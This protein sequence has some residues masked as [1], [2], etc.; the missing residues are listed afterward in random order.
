MDEKVLKAVTVLTGVLTLVVCISL[1]FLPK[2]HEK[3]ALAAEKE[4][5]IGRADL[6]ASAD[7][8]DVVKKADD[9]SAQIK[10]GLPQQLT[11]EQLTIK[12]DY[13][14]QTVY[15]RFSGGVDDY[16]DQYGIQGNCDHIASLFYYRDGDEGVIAFGL[17]RVYEVEQ[18]FELG[19]LYLDFV[20]PHTIYDKVIVIDAGHGDRAPGVVKLGIAEKDIDL[21]ILLE[22][23][24][25]LE[26]CP[27]N[28]GVYYTRTSD[29]NPTFEQRVQLANKA[30]ADLFISI[31]NNSDV[32]GNFTEANGTHVM[33]SESNDK[34]LSGQKLAQICLDN[35]TDTLGSKNRGVLAG[36]KIYILRNS[37]VPAVLVEVGFMTNYEEL[38]QLKTKEYQQKAAKGIYCA[39]MEA[40]EEGY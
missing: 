21:N 23:R 34:E 14:T 17:D 9:I 8:K 37:E 15:I 16:F 39:I 18:K 13:L 29:I 10:I 40:F 12:N 1:P 31:H 36:D 24:K 6:V 38:M 30:D 11:E 27:D 7:P 4:Q 2:L 26:D 32:T 5:E 3:E 35:I 25:L 33:Y 28:I 19:N 20:D 22:L